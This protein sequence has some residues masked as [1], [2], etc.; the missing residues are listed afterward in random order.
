LGLGLSTLVN[1]FN[2]S[3]VVLDY[4]LGL[5]GESLLDQIARIVRKQALGNATANLE[6]ACGTL[7]SDAG[8][9]GAALNV[10]ESIFEI[11]ALKPPRFMVEG[12]AIDALAANRRAWSEDSSLQPF[13]PNPL[14]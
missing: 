13:A 10:L 11:P 3:I 6:F 9:L 1:L 12:S 2:P 7:G 8:I 5:G 4:R 14:S